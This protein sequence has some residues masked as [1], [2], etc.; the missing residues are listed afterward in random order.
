MCSVMRWAI[1]LNVVTSYSKFSI[2]LS[3]NMEMRSSDEGVE[4]RRS[5]ST[6]TPGGAF[7]ESSDD[8][9]AK[10]FRVRGIV[11]SLLALTYETNKGPSR[12]PSVTASYCFV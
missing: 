9:R 7:D 11:R 2:V 4:N 1:A 3:M 10:C 5:R 6:F 8:E 12:Y